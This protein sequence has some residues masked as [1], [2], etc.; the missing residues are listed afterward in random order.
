MKYHR[1]PNVYFS[2][3]SGRE[4]NDIFKPALV[5]DSSI[6]YDN[7]FPAILSKNKK[8]S[9]NVSLERMTERRPEYGVKSP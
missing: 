6:E 2:K 3:F 8:I 7:I 5:D 1:P 4:S 9:V